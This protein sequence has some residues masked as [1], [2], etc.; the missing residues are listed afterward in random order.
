MGFLINLFLSYHNQTVRF[1]RTFILSGYSSDKI[2][3]RWHCTIVLIDEIRNELARYSLRV[4]IINA[5]SMRKYEE[6]LWSPTVACL[7]A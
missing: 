2:E 3:C 4:A 7:K 5:S 1:L 6:N